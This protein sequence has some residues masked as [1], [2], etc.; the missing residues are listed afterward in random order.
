MILDMRRF[1]SV[2]SDMRRFRFAFAFLSLFRF[3]S[4]RILS[5]NVSSVAF[6]SLFAVA[7]SEFLAKMFLSVA[8]F[9]LERNLSENSTM[10]AYSLRLRAKSKRFSK[11]LTLE[12][13]K[14]GPWKGQTSPKS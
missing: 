13:F 4:E 14:K 11:A 5:E 8:F 3:R 10:F 6:F 12:V 7:Q 2:I 9:H 1:R